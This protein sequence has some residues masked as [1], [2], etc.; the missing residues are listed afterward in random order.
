MLVTSE[1]VP[2]TW[3]RL[4]LELFPSMSVLADEHYKM[5]LV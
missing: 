1:V 5:A 3:L 4:L 2:L